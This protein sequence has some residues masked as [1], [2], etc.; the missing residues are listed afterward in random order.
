MAS[1]IITT[2]FNSFFTF[3]PDIGGDIDKE[4][5]WTEMKQLYPPFKDEN[6]SSSDFRKAIFAFFEN[7]DITFWLMLKF[8]C[9]LHDLVL[10]ILEF[11]FNYFDKYIIKKLNAIIAAKYA[12]LSARTNSL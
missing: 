8:D 10:V 2:S 11:R 12:E 6:I 9:D 4:N 1:G 7:Y 3:D 5:I